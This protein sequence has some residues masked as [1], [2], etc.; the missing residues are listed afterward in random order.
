MFNALKVNRNSSPLPQEVSMVA[1]RAPPIELRL[2]TLVNLL[3]R[4]LTSNLEH[5]FRSL[6]LRR[7]FVAPKEPGSN[8]QIAKERLQLSR[9][10]VGAVSLTS[11]TSVGNCKKVI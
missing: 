10:V 11:R 2:L 1:S 9:Y 3:A 7:N 8:S 6:A 4:R 5:W